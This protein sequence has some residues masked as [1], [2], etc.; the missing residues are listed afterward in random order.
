MNEEG[1]MRK[2]ESPR[3]HPSS[4]RLHPWLHTLTPALSRSTG[5]GSKHLHDRR[6]FYALRPAVRTYCGP[7]EHTIMLNPKRRSLTVAFTALLAVAPFARADDAPLTERQ[8]VV[9]ALNRLA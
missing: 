6:F 8:K 3:F 9:H 2:D 7:P 5:R 1:G 4:F